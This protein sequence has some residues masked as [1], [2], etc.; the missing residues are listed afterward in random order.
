MLKILCS[1]PRRAW[2]V[3]TRPE[4][5]FKKIV[6]D[7]SFEDAVIKAFLYGML[8]GFAIFVISLIGG[9]AI[10][11]GGFFVKIFVYPIVAVG[12]L[13]A[14][15]GLMMLLSEITGGNRDWELAV[16]GVS[17]IF[18]MYPVILIVDS[19][20][21]SCASLWLI[22]IFVDGYVLFLLYNIA[23]HCMG[24]KKLAVLVAIGGI[25]VLLCSIYGSGYGALWLA[26]KNHSVACI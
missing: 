22:S 20:A 2:L 9:G 6:V 1:I 18:F 7:G 26:A 24:G 15:A 19:L 5:F 25:A 16:K 11:F 17:S 12:V 21:W 8:G 3:L 10:H 4:R 14:F 23:Y 13:F